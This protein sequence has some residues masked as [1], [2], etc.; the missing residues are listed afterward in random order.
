M[1]ARR[2]VVCALAIA[3]ACGCAGVCSARA[4]V[5]DTLTAAAVAALKQ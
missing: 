2:F 4:R 5:E 1:S 3:V